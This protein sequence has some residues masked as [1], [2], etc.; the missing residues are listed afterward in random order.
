MTV[1]LRVQDILNDRRVRPRQV[2]VFATCFLIALLDGFDTQSI[3]FIG[4]SIAEDFGL[5]ATD[6]A[7]VITASTVGMALGAMTLGTLGDRLGRK[8]TILVAL[9]IFGA[10]SLLGAFATALWQIVALRFLIGLGMGGATP[11]LLS[12]AAEFSPSRLRGTVMTIVLLGLPGGAMIGGLVA[13]EWLPVLGWRGIF[14]VG[15]LLPLVLLALAAVV[16]PESPAF[17]VSRGRRG[18]AQRARHIIAKATGAPVA[19]GVVLEPET[20]Q[21]SQGSVR[22]LFSSDYRLATAGIWATYLF[23][24]IA[25][26]LLLLWLPTALKTLG[27]SAESAAF[28]TVTVNAA[29]I[30]MALPVSYF[31]PRVN[32]R[33]LL[34]VMFAVG[35]VVAV[36]LGL[37]GTNWPLVFGLIALAGFGIGGGQLAL[38]YLIASTYPTEL[39][40]TATGWAIGIGRTGSIIGSAVGGA[41]LANVGVARY[42][43]LLAVPL[44]IA[45]AAT[46]LVRTPGAGAS[47]RTA[48][49]STSLEAT[50]DVALSE[51]R[52]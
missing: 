41:L 35:T 1:S 21:V 27:L 30:V 19:P 12:L 50:E 45:A 47:A 23:N 34:L 52:R 17:Y 32:A 24:W 26:F 48:T 40:S 16:L 46:T 7:L 4:P 38:N 25:W 44:V 18:D 13:A 5:Q 37:A 51:A 15:G 14:L 9:V 29:F 42:F 6:M 31:L 39:R 22:A 36:G 3:A 10:F 43:M 2:A 33:R 28:G 11:A 8:K 49:P 20:R